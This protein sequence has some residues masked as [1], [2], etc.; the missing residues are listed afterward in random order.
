M[1]CFL[2][3]LAEAAAVTA[4]RA[5]VSHKQ[6]AETKSECL[7][8]S[9]GSLREKLG[10]LAQ[11][12]FGGSAL[13]MIEHIFHGEVVLYPPFLTA[14]NSPDEMYAMLHEMSTVGVGMACLVTGVW[15]AAVII[16]S[17][18]KKLKKTKT[19]AVQESN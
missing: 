14:M 7:H 11:M 13:L 9:E 19:A 8:K 12:L 16:S 6:N 4:V 3:P 5:L 15:G 10:W 1:A 17:L 18:M 2:V